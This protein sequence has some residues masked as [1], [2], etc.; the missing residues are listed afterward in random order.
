[1]SFRESGEG[2]RA[3]RSHIDEGEN[4]LTLLKLASFNKF[5]VYTV[6]ELSAVDT[7]WKASSY[8]LEAKLV[9]FML[10]LCH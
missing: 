4:L 9:C 1:M 7:A 2:S 8:L 6:G 10:Y 5:F 3:K